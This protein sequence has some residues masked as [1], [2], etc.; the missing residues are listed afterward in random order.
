MIEPPS[1]DILIVDDD[2]L[3]RED[4]VDWF[5][6]K[7]YQVEEAGDGQEALASC[8]QRL[9]H[10]AIVDMKM[11][12]MSGLE[13][14]EKLQAS[15]AETEVIILTGEGTVESAVSAMKL[16]A[17]DFLMK[18]F[19][20]AELE[21]RCRLAFQHGKL[22]KENTQLKQAIKRSRVKAE[23][24]GESPQIQ[25]VFRLIDRV[26]PTNSGVLI[27]G[28]SG[29]GKELVARALMERSERVD[30][31]FVTINCAA[32]P[33]QLVES[34]L[35]GYEKGSFTGATS[36][37]PGLFEVADGGTLFIDE[38][39]ELPL[40]MQ[41]K[42]LRVLEDGSIRRI[43]STKTRRVDA[44]IIAATNR[45]LEEEVKAGRFR[46]DLFYRINV[47]TLDLPPIRERNGDIE[48]L[49]RH[50]LEP[51]WDIE[52]QA[53]KVLLEYD[54]PGNVRQL[55]NAIEHAMIMADDLEVTLQDL[56]S[57]LLEAARISKV[58]GSKPQLKETHS[59]PGGS[60]EGRD[61]VSG[62]SDGLT[63]TRRVVD[64]L[65]STDW[66][67]AKAAKKLGISRSTLYQRIKLY[68]LKRPIE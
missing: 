63:E 58:D 68:G 65:T 44:R 37:K 66:N 48:L 56:P 9:F 43:G 13:L 30:R 64:A 59:E 42:L 67:I 23:M 22:R 52:D 62:P 15:N 53:L 60:A 6:R 2:P 32:L 57:Q 39:G 50:L 54:W 45:V 41:P 55:Q 27:Q 29:T 4:C 3:F 10:V 1:F 14:L 8:E 24:V 18:P 26:G 31:P 47:V 46:E 40:A 51:E 34:E 20:L 16:G 33:E 21:R 17:Y 5:T 38:I 36:A 35:F 25:Q 19:P 28:E 49:V 61:D 12:E 7:G 11:P